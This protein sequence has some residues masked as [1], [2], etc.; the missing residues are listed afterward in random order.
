MPVIVPFIAA[1]IAVLNHG[2]ALRPLVRE[3]R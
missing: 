2:M 1:P 3:V